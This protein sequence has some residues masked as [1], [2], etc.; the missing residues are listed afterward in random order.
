MEAFFAPISVRPEA[1]GEM[2]MAAGDARSQNPRTGEV[3]LA[4]ALGNRPPAR[5]AP[6]DPRP[7]QVTQDWLNEFD[8]VQWL[9][10][11]SPR[12]RQKHGD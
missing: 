9:L 11:L 8:R 12:L 6:G 10:R 1:H 7:A 5:V 3:A 2:V 4:H